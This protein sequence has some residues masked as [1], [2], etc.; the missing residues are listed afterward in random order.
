MTHPNQAKVV[1]IDDDP[2]ILTLLR[3]LFVMENYEVSPFTSAL[4]ALKK[5]KGCDLILCDLNLPEMNGLAF[6]EKLKALG[7]EIPVILITADGSVETAVEA[8]KCGAFDYVVKPIN[9]TELS[10]LAG[11][12]VKLRRLEEEKASL[13]DQ[14]NRTGS[15]GQMVGRSQKIQ[16][17]FDLIE[18]VAKSNANVLITGESGT[19]KEMAARAIHAK[20]D[21][22]S[23]P[24][25]AINC[26]A[27]PDNLLESELFGHRKG[28]FTGAS[29]N[30]RGLFE[31]AE[32]GTVFLDEIGDMP[33][34]LQAK[35]L[36]VLQERK[37]KPIGENQDR[38]IDI[39]VV[40][41]T[42]E[43][44]KTLVQQEKFR[45]DLYYRLCVIPVSIPP[46]RER[47]EDIPLLAEYFLKKYCELNKT[48]PKRF[49]KAAIV[50]IVRLPWPGNVR[51]LE[52]AVERSVVLSAQDTID[53]HEFHSENISSTG[54]KLNSLFQ[55]LPSLEELEKRYITFVLNESGHAKEKVAE[56]LGINRKTLYRKE[57]IYGITAAIPETAESVLL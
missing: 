12:A 55:K 22:S 57:Q 14:L 54:D 43:D 47:Q 32:G 25:V 11:R 10:V 23:H 33:L 26:S 7:L 34:M 24:F 19:G 1:V 44:L 6:I 37:I 15:L 50:K 48:S 35:L 16:V 3:K 2:E 13:Q 28:S 53:E 31:E 56:I 27:I 4:E 8:M 36:R 20:S 46:L 49:T 9:L 18:R 29:E 45:E 21:R 5:V 52:N 41:A 17:T 51:E 38:D 39:R 42:H 40:A 30:R